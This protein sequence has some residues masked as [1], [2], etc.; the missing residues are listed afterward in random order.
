MQRSPL[1]NI[2][3]AQCAG[4]GRN[5]GQ[6]LTWVMNEGL[7]ARNGDRRQGENVIVLITAGA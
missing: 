3:I 7:T 6:A 5:I 2:A 1:S 4:T